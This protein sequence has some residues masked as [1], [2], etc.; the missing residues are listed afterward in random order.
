M[1]DRYFFVADMLTLV[2]AFVAPRYWSAAILFQIGSLGAYLAYFGVT[3]YGPVFAL[4][5]V[6]LAVGVVMLAFLEA[7]SMSSIS[8][9]DVF[10]NLGNRI[11]KAERAG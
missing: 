5:P 9:R 2:L 7:Q 4:V 3:P 1:H 8:F 10:H 11:R 6:T